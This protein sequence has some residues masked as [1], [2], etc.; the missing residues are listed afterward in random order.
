MRGTGLERPRTKREKPLRGWDGGGAACCALLLSVLVRVGAR[1][2]APSSPWL[3]LVISARFPRCP[4][5]RCG[6][7]STIGQHPGVYCWGDKGPP[8]RTEYPPEQ[9]GSRHCLVR[10]DGG[11]FG[12]GRFSTSSRPE[13]TSVILKF[14][15]LPVLHFI[16][17]RKVGKQRGESPRE[18]NNLPKVTEQYWIWSALYPRHVSSLLLAS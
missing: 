6:F 9:W 15:R 10:T 5:S 14:P 4:Q 3:S 16:C 2:I 11:P 13:K 18:L 1:F 8:I 7:H 17:R 12:A